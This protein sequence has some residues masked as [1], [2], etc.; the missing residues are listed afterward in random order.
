LITISV[1]GI[2]KLLKILEGLKPWKIRI[3]VSIPIIE[4]ELDR[5]IQIIRQDPNIPRE[6]KDAL[7]S[8]SN[9]A[10]GE[11]YLAIYIPDKLK[12]KKFGHY[13][14]WRNY[15]CPIRKYWG[16]ELSP[17]YT[18]PNYLMQLWNQHKT[19]IIKNIKD[20]IIEYIRSTIR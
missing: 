12:Y 18:G 4:K 13:M 17:A 11:V 14:V 1:E 2:D 5:F 16:G 6:Y 3:N 15:R 7:I 10:I 8:W 20:K 19:N 9:K